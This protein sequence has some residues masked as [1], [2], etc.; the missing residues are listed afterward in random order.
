M[1]N[2]FR[3]KAIKWIRQHDSMQC[4]V[5]CLAMICRH[6]GKCY[7]LEYL[8]DLVLA[9]QT[10]WVSMFRHSRR[11]RMCG[12]ETSTFAATTDELVE[13]KLPLHTAFSEPESFCGALY[14]ISRNGG[15]YR[16]ADPE[17]S[18]RLLPE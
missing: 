2:L 3:S 10:W 16:V 18:D 14:D 4:G 6:Y 9:M 11:C 15:R 13:I 8:G 1:M 7:S 5:A 17:R 12:L